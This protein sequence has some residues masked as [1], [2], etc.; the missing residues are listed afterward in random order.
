MNRD[1]T[2]RFQFQGHLGTEKAKSPRIV[3]TIEYQLYDPSTLKIDLLFLGDKNEQ[4]AASSYLRSLRYN[5]VWLYSDDEQVPSVE[6]LGIHRTGEAGPH[7]SIGALAVHVGLT[8]KPLDQDTTYYIKAELT[9]S[10]I[11]AK[12]GSRELSFTGDLR[13][14][15]IVEGEIKVPTTFGILQAE[16]RFDHYESEESGNRIIH[17]VQRAAIT[18]E[19][20]VS[21]GDDLFT[22]NE[23]FQ[24]DIEEICLLLSLC[25]R[26]PVDYYEIHY[27]PD[28]KNTSKCALQ[29]SLLRRKRGASVKKI[30]EDD[31]INYRN[32]IGDGLDR[33][34]KSYRDFKRKDQ[35]SQAIKFL[36]SSYKAIT[37]ESSYF[38][39]FSALESAIAACS[40]ISPLLLTAGKWKR[41]EKLLRTHLNQIAVVEDFGGVLD[42]M[43]Q[44]LPELRRIPS[45]RWILETC[46]TLNLKTEDLWPRDGFEAGLRSA[47]QMRNDLFHSALCRDFEVM[48]DNLVR[49]RLLTERLILRTL[50]WPEDEVW[51]WYDQNLKWINKPQL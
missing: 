28:P 45:D 32:L 42:N 36:S 2:K 40:E 15:P 20:K 5:H 27:L 35:L 49:L 7:F 22:V 39:C 17:T 6:V 18:G 48:A 46:R 31:L 23:K 1:T 38:L 37:L 43:K 8:K 33:L 4:Q 11:L 24:T 12:P 14:T 3:S 19:I 9:P 13:F 34:L 50:R 30:D 25:Y 44:K 47:T 26:L 29:D 41:V 16:E 10:G 21:K 51:R